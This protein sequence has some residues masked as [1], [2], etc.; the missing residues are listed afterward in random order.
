MGKTRNLEME[1]CKSSSMN[2]SLV[3]RH[4]SCL[5]SRLRMR[6]E[7]LA[8]HMNLVRNQ[9]Q[10]LFDIISNIWITRCER[11]LSLQTC[12]E[13]SAVDAAR[14]PWVVIHAANSV[15]IR[16]VISS[17]V[18]RKDVEIHF[19][20]LLPNWRKSAKDLSL[21]CFWDSKPTC[22]YRCNAETSFHSYRVWK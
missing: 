3:W 9:F 11:I 20:L 19:F 17:D 2:C 21:S 4:W 22:H 15:H 5:S 1:V 12:Y 13:L 10:T 7:E 16:G 6:M 18:N 14:D 8:Q